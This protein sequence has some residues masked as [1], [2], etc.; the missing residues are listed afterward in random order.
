VFGSELAPEVAARFL[1]E[2]S[3]GRYRFRQQYARYGVQYCML[4]PAGVCTLV[5]ACVCVCPCA[6]T[7]ACP[8]LPACSE[9]A[10][11]TTPL[12]LGLGSDL[13]PEEAETVR[14]GLLTL[15]QNVVLLKDPEDP[16]AYYPVRAV[17][18]MLWLCWGCCA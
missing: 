17:L 5:R 13:L 1:Q 2:Q 6:F 7:T 15:R 18:C 8:A 10:L 3:E 11:A 12:R 16:N 14:R 9:A 4:L